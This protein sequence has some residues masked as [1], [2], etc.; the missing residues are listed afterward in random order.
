VRLADELDEDMRRADPL[1]HAKL[2]L[3]PESQFYWRFN[4]RIRGVKVD[5]IRREILFNVAF[6]R[7]DLALFEPG[8][9]GSFV[10]L[11]I[12]KILKVNRE[13]VYCNKFLSDKLAIQQI[14][15][16]LQ[17]VEGTPM[18]EATHLLLSDASDL[19]SVL[20]QLPS[21]LLDPSWKGKAVRARTSGAQPSRVHVQPESE[22]E[23]VINGYKLFFAR[24][25]S[26][27]SIKSLSKQSGV[28]ARLINNLEQV[29]VRAP[30]PQCFKSAPRTALSQLEHTLGRVGRLEYGQD[31]DLLV[32]P[33]ISTVT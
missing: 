5:S 30:A 8:V 4:A 22:T 19:E 1:L 17:P 28:D 10:E 15:I 26:R 3:P 6:V 2:D 12:K 23:A 21:V 11:C 20:T 33:A 9:D 18:T 31:D 13:R 25:N 32:P 16:C 29:R 24:T 27:L 7:D 14:H